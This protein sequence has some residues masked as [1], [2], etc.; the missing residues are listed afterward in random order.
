M[1]MLQVKNLPTELHAALAARSR[2]Q[3]VTMSEYVTRLLERDLSRPSVDD[4]IAERRRAATPVRAIDVVHALDAV[5]VEY[6]PED[7]AHANTTQQT[8]V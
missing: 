8:R 3:G 5:R 7:S 1:S 2:A 6:D 4:W